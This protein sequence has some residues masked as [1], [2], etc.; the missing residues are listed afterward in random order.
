MR[1][2]PGLSGLLT[3]AMALL[4]TTGADM[5][6]AQDITAASWGGAYQTSQREAYFKPYAK[7]ASVTVLEDEWSGELSQIRVQVET[8]NYK[9]HV[10]DV[11]TDHVLAG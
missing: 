3:A 4:G 7:E 9:W 6:V 1:V 11:E 10:V 2:K 8:D 5:A